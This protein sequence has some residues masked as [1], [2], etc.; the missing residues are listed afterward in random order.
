MLNYNCLKV[1]V[2]HFTVVIY[3]LHTQKSIFDRLHVHSKNYSAKFKSIR[4]NFSTI[5]VLG[6]G[7]HY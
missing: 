1:T 7:Q 5:K 4:A 3:G 6:G 2:S